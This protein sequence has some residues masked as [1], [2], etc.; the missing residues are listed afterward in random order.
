MIT[1]CRQSSLEILHNR[2]NIYSQHKK[3]QNTDI[4]SA[5]YIV[6]NSLRSKYLSILFFV[7][8]AHALK[9][10]LHKHPTEKAIVY[11]SLL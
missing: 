3:K 10:T 11:E 5:C 6:K 8:L 9:W 2:L 7:T 1:S 4:D